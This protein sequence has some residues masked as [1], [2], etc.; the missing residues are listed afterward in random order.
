M[1]PYLVQ[2]PGTELADVTRLFGVSEDALL[3]DLN[4]L[5]LAG[6]PPYGPGD[7]IDVDIDDD[8]RVWIDMADYFG[9][10]LRLTRS[11]ALALYL[12]G[13]ELLGAPGLPEAEAL[14]SA[15]TKLEDRLGP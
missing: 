7:L 4:L 3:D 6:L 5:F 15:L 8:G 10:P 12:R 11:E 9:R 1:V 2:H 13:K 14:G